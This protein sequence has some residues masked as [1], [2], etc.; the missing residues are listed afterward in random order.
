MVAGIDVC[1]L[2]ELFA[3]KCDAA[4]GNDDDSCIGDDSRGSARSD[5]LAADGCTDDT[6]K[7]ALGRPDHPAFHPGCVPALRAGCESTARSCSGGSS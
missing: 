7:G 3:Y 4:P 5:G 1:P 6:D 2:K